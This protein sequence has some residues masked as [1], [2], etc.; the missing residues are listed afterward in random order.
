MELLLLFYGLNSRTTV[1]FKTVN[2]L[3]FIVH[4]TILRLRLIEKGIQQHFLVRKAERGRDLGSWYSN[5]VYLLTN[6]S[7]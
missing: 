6:R 2:S 4:S 3:N 1:V 7:M 5:E